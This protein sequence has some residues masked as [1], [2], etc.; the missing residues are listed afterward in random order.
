MDG[1][2]RA[3]E[4][5]LRRRFSLRRRCL[6][7]ILYT[8]HFSWAVS[9]LLLPLMWK[10]YRVCIRFSDDIQRLMTANKLTIFIHGCGG[11]LLIVAMIMQ[12]G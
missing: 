6:D 4:R 3:H 10:S 9:L 5:R 12:K 7:L 8:G 1:I 2:S 11:V